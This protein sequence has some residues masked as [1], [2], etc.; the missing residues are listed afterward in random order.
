MSSRRKLYLLW[1]TALSVPLISLLFYL[2]L[3]TLYHCFNTDVGIYLQAM[4]GIGQGDFNPYSSVRDLPIF[5]DHL[6]PIIFLGAFFIKIFNYHPL[7]LIYFEFIW[8]VIFLYLIF[9]F[10]RKSEIND[11][12]YC[13]FL[14]TLAIFCKGIFSS[15]RFPTHPISWSI[16]PLLMLIWSLFKND[17]KKIFLSFIFLFLFKE[18]FPLSALFFGGYCLLIKRFRLGLGILICSSLMLYLNFGVLHGENA[19]TGGHA[20][21]LND[22]L[23]HPL[24]FLL[25]LLSQLD[26]AAWF[27]YFFPFILPLIFYIGALKDKNELF[28]LK[29]MGLFLFFAPLFGMHFLKNKIYL[30]YGAQ[31]NALLFGL[32]L[33]PAVIQKIQSRK[34]WMPLIIVIFVLSGFKE[35]ELIFRQWVLQKNPYCKINPMVQ[36]DSAELLEKIKEIPEKKTILTIGELLPTLISMNLDTYQINGFSKHL[37]QYDYLLLRNSPDI[38]SYN[39]SW[40]QMKKIKSNCEKYF[41]RILVSN[42]NYFLVNGPILN[43]CIEAK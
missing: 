16:V 8:L 5:N 32:F 18:V 33:Y 38:E 14:F 39:I 19:A 41:S 11:V 37:T 34:Y 4:M 17:D 42:Q 22:L 43:H 13:L 28:G 30:H 20:D 36:K 21:V 23:K 2:H 24:D 7:A 26:W 25:T 10:Y 15:F 9:Y 6:D 3:G 40:Q 1:A 35:H 29:G 27:K 31:F 12:K